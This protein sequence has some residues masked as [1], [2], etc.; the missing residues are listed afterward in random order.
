MRVG[1]ATINA[2]AGGGIAA[3]PYSK[4]VTGGL[5][6]PEDVCNGILGSLVSITAPCAVVHSNEA[7]FIGFIGSILAL[8]TNALTLGRGDTSRPRKGGS[9]LATLSHKVHCSAIKFY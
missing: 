7:I 1:A 9:P 5:V 3:L 6:R 2:T 4:T 8:L